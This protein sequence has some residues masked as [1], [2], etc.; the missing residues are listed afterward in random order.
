M[1]NLRTA[2]TD[3]LDKAHTGERYTWDRISEA[4][5]FLA[6]YMS[7]LEQKTDTQ[8]VHYLEALRLARDEQIHHEYNRRGLKPR[9][10][11]KGFVPDTLPKVQVCGVESL[12]TDTLLNELSKRLT[13]VF[14]LPEVPPKHVQ[15][16]NTE[17]KIVPLMEFGKKPKR[18]KRK[19]KKAR[20][21]K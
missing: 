19:T 12:S 2:I 7:K 13:K 18:Q 3:T 16:R 10:W 11:D 1:Q 15:C 8:T 14:T 20:A 17:L 4:R 21:R 5:L 6:K 9:P